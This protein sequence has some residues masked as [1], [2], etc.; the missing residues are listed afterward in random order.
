MA[1]VCGETANR[2]DHQIQ[3]DAQSIVGFCVCVDH[4]FFDS[5]DG[6][7]LGSRFLGYFVVSVF[8]LFFTKLNLGP[9]I[10]CTPRLF[11]EVLVNLFLIFTILPLGIYDEL[12][13]L[14]G[15]I[16]VF[17][18]LGSSKFDFQAI[19]FPHSTGLYL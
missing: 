19:L 7:F 18:V 1:L 15:A 8:P 6:F 14:L 11:S 2:I 17:F 5:E 12:R 9:R 3:Q 4:I 10:F 16:C 13:I